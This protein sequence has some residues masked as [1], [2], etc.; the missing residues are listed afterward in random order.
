[1]ARHHQAI[2]EAEEATPVAEPEVPA[3]DGNAVAEAVDPAEMLEADLTAL[4]QRLQEQEQLASENHDKFL[5]TLAEFDNYRRRTKQEIDDAR[6]SAVERLAGDLL[7]VLDNFERALQH[8]GDGGEDDPVL[9]GILLIHKQL[10]DALA[11]HEIQPIEAMGKT[12]DPQFHEAIMKAEPEGGQEPGTVVQELRKGYTIGGRVLRA[13][14]V[15]VAG[16]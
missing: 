13:S 2:R 7:P 10:V 14:L 12:F 16:D 4:M 15:K 6:R 3:V 1:M 5:R 11:K 9:Q 8:A